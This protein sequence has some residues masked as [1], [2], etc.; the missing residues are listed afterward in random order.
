MTPRPIAMLLVVSLSLCAAALAIAD[1]DRWS[2]K[3]P[4]GISLSE[5][6]GYESWDVIASSMPDTEGGCGTSKAPGCIKSTVGN[7]T[8][9]DAYKE[10]IPFNGKAAPDG[11]AF[12]KIEWAKARSD[13]PY[14]ATIPGALAEVSF[15]LKDS[16]RFSRTNGW[17]Y[18]TFRYD[19]ASDTWSVGHAEN[20][21]FDSTCH[22]C[23]TVVK[24]NDFVFTKYPKR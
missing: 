2:L 16:K 18:A 19:V 17:G 4:N 6:K 13:A 20:P 14:P 15:M 5:F 21:Q 23:H 22:G 10:G 8:M 3:A 24:A 12:A 7:P 1:A 9:I 11:A